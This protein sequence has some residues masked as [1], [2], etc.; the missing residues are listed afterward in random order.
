MPWLQMRFDEVL[1]RNDAYL[2][3]LATVLHLNG[4]KQDG[5]GNQD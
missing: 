4:L 1:V 2:A 3:Y 5:T